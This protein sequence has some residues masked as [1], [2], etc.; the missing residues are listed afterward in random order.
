MSLLAGGPFTAVACAEG[1]IRTSDR[2]EVLYCRWCFWILSFLLPSRG[3]KALFCLDGGFDLLSHIF[4]GEK[5]VLAFLEN[6]LGIL[7]NFTFYF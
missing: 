2:T 5:E 1:I 6:F 7:R 4:T 3:F